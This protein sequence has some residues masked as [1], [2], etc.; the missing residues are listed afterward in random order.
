MEYDLILKHFLKN[1]NNLNKIEAK[2]SLDYLYC[3]L[4]NCYSKNPFK[5]GGKVKSKITHEDY[6]DCKNQCIVHLNRLNL[7][8]N[9]VYQDFTKFYYEKFLT[10]SQEEEEE[11]YTRCITDTKKLMAKNVEEIK[12]LL[13]NY[14]Y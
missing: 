2:L 12:T 4:E 13:L 1:D 5:A 11:K 3:K 6:E 8:K 10:C 14:K 9:F 7:M